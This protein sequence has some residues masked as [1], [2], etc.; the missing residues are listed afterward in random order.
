MI[1]QNWTIIH[2]CQSGGS[3]PLEKGTEQYLYCCLQPCLSGSIA[4]LVV[5]CPYLEHMANKQPKQRKMGHLKKKSNSG[6][7]NLASSFIVWEQRS[8]NSRERTNLISLAIFSTL[9]YG[10]SRSTIFMFVFPRFLQTMSLLLSRAKRR[11]PWSMQTTGQ[12]M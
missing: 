7:N 11:I 5:K 3:F 2:L 8:F 4:L 10:T 1:S 6:R 12:T 9:L